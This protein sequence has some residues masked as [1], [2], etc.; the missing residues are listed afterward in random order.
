MPI[1]ATGRNLTTRFNGIKLSFL[2]NTCRDY[3]LNDSHA[4][5]PGL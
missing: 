4:K 5:L 1:L 2:K 3:L